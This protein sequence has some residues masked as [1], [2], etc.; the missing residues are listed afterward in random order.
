M[1]ANDRYRE[2]GG[3]ENLHELRSRRRGTGSGPSPL[4]GPA[5]SVRRFVFRVVSQTLGLSAPND[6]APFERAPLARDDGTLALGPI[7]VVVN[8]DPVGRLPHLVGPAGV[9]EERGV[10]TTPALRVMHGEPRLALWVEAPGG[11][12]GKRPGPGPFPVL[13]VDVQDLPDRRRGLDAPRGRTRESRAA[14]ES[15]IA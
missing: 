12:R 15:W 10:L 7:A 8:H 6:P 4:A 5:V 13:P 14:S 11:D 1:R 9:R 3:A 2:P